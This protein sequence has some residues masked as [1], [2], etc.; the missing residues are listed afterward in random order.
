MTNR[1]LLVPRVLDSILARSAGVLHLGI[2]GAER[3]L[4]KIVAASYRCYVKGTDTM[5]AAIPLEMAQE[6]RTIAEGANVFDFAIQGHFVRDDKLKQS[7][8]DYIFRMGPMRA[9]EHASSLP[10]VEGRHFISQTNA[11]L[12]AIRDLPQN[13]LNGTEIDMLAFDQIFDHVVRVRV[14]LGSGVAESTN[15]KLLSSSTA[16]WLANYL[17]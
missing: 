13:D 2:V 7:N 14:M 3:G 4:D 8:F 15:V 6:S 9:K 12:Q 17:P 10:D 16:Q 5:I 1:V 11:W